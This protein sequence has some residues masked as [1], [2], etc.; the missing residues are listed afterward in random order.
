M[1]TFIEEALPSIARPV[2]A[3]AQ[4]LLP[5]SQFLMSPEPMARAIAGSYPSRTDEEENVEFFPGSSQ[6]LRVYAWESDSFRDEPFFWQIVAR[7]LR[8]DLK[9]REGGKADVLWAP[10]DPYSGDELAELLSN[11]A[12]PVL[13]EA[14]QRARQSGR[15][16]IAG[17]DIMSAAAYFHQRAAEPPPQASTIAAPLAEPSSPDHKEELARPFF[18]DVSSS[19]GLSS[20]PIPTDPM[21]TAALDKSFSGLAVLDYEG[22][23]LADIFLC[24]SPNRLL[25]N[26]GNFKFADA[27][28]RVGPLG[29]ACNTA[30]SADYDNDGRPDLLLL[31][32]NQRGPNLQLFRNDKGLRFQDVTAGLKL[33]SAPMLP[34]SSVWLD[35]DHDGLLDLYV[36][37]FGD[38]NHK[39]IPTLGD[40]KN[41]LPNRLLRNNG[42]GSF[43][44]V[45]KAAGVGDT[46]WGLAAAAFD[47]DNDGWSDL[48]VGND[49]GR[50]V[51]YR[52]M[53]NGTFQD[54]SLKAGVDSFGHAM[55]VSVADLKH[56]GFLDILVT[57][58]GMYNPG[59]RYIR[60]SDRTPIQYSPTLERGVRIHEANRLYLNRG[61][62]KFEDVYDS[63]VEPVSTG[64]GW[65]GMFFD[66]DNDGDQDMYVVNGLA[67]NLIF[68]ANERKVLFHWDAQTRKFVDVSSGSGSDFGGVS[69]SAAFADFDRDGG[70]DIIVVNEDG[71]KLLRNVSRQKG[72]HWLELKL[73]GKA[74]PR[75]GFG[76]RVRVAAGV[77]SREAEF[78]TEGG[79]YSLAS[80]RV[81]HFGLGKRAALDE[82]VIRWPSGKVQK[83]RGVPVDRRL[84]IREGDDRWT[85]VGR[86][87]R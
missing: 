51:L 75:D 77:W 83:L 53:G 60:P 63:W 76:A 58:I 57:N 47:F 84:L 87:K 1:K 3:K 16:S 28:A 33:S 37:N 43:T 52:N 56:N 61:D 36:V 74:S 7:M 59:T 71:I 24:G 85:S 65:S 79:G 30:S 31:N 32:A 6:P 12:V 27:T 68:Y 62:G 38:R 15:T 73:V 22:D 8:Q 66:F 29:E 10:L 44:D 9:K 14:A 26:M 39:V 18:V 5:P 72:R 81:V 4:T 41:G 54:V 67:S 40:A 64:W 11:I 13:K 45:T 19:S 46:G 86:P 2:W 70:Q 55:G 20:A 50:S 23:G 35:Y 17:E 21:R 82:V 34:S 25:K 49:Y 48:F 69:R 42:D 78:G 80:E